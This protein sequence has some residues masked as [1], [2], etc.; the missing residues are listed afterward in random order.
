MLYREINKIETT[1]LLLK[2]KD[3][4]WVKIL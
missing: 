4:E 1:I 2:M 3:V